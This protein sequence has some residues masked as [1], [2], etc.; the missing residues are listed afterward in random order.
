[1]NARLDLPIRGS[2]YDCHD[3]H[4]GCHDKCPKYKEYR[5]E[6]DT[7]RKEEEKRRQY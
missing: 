3:R 6:I 4:P 5:K 2:C 7:L 1:M